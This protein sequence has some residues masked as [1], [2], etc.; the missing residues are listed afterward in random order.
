MLPKGDQ[1]DPPRSF[2]SIQNR[3]KT[4]YRDAPLWREAPQHLMQSVRA[5]TKDWAELRLRRIRQ[6]T[7]KYL[8]QQLHKL[9]LVAAKPLYRRSRRCPI[10]FKDLVE[11]V[12]CSCICRPAWPHSS[13]SSIKG[14][15]PN[16]RCAGIQVAS[17][18]SSSMART[19]PANTSGSR[20][21]A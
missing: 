15:A 2:S 10:C 20:G 17:R 14:S 8:R 9:Q 4:R 5:T 12:E 6:I 7:R 16:A 13:R 18:P 11:N 21:V 1:D 3:R 19:T